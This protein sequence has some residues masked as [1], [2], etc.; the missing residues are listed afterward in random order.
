MR[1]HPGPGVP[2]RQP[3]PGRKPPYHRTWRGCK[4]YHPAKLTYIRIF[5]GAWRVSYRLGIANYN[6]V[7]GNYSMGVDKIETAFQVVG[8]DGRRERKMTIHY[9]YTS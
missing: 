6:M 2:L 4:Q 8:V 5:S 7:E 9:K 3:S 1:R